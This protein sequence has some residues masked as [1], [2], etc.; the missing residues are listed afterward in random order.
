MVIR[1]H[2]NGRVN[3]EIGWLLGILRQ[4]RF[5]LYEPLYPSKDKAFVYHLHNVVPMSKRFG[6]RCTNVI[7]MLCVYCGI[8]CF[9][10]DFFFQ[11]VLAE[12]RESLG[13]RLDG[14]G[15]HVNKLN[16]FKPKIVFFIYAVPKL[17]FL[18]SVGY[19]TGT[20]DPKSPQ[21][22]QCFSRII[23]NVAQRKIISL[24]VHI[25]NYCLLK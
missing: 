2:V 12:L 9:I 18:Y 11:K 13:E 4:T 6:R 8:V 20:Y 25:K 23:L 21:K 1:N 3:D 7:Q 16:I 17:D 14:I 5:A 19:I 10:H 24:N 22:T 15:M